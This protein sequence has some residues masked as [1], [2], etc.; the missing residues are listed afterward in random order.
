MSGLN[1]QQRQQLYAMISDDTLAGMLVAMRS[2]ERTK[3]LQEVEQLDQTLMDR[4][5][6][7]IRFCC[8]HLGHGTISALCSH[9]CKGW[10]P[11]I[12]SNTA[13]VAAA[14]VTARPV[15]AVA[16]IAATAAAADVADVAAAAAAALVPAWHLAV[17][18]RVHCSPEPIISLDPAPCLQFSLKEHSAAGYFIAN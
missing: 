13:G 17:V 11:H 15:G 1:S 16:A 9:A 18:S 4:A 3:L 7:Y 6:R 8:M 12:G 5:L 14:D 2:A 10:E